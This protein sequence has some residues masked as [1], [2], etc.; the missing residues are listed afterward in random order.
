VQVNLPER[1]LAE[2]LRQKQF[3]VSFDIEGCEV[4]RGLVDEHRRPLN[5]R[6]DF[7]IAVKNLLERQTAK[8]L[9]FPL[10]D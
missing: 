1:A 6:Y 4:V 3:T 10:G 5:L 2:V 9:T 7:S 8:Q